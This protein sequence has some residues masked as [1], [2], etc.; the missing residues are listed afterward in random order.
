VVAHRLVHI[1]RVQTRGVEAGQPHVADDDDANAAVRV[2]ELGRERLHLALAPP[3]LRQLGRVV[4][5]GGD[6]ALDSIIAETLAEQP[7]HFGGDPARVGDDHRLAFERLDALGVVLGEI[8]GDL[9]EP[10]VLADDPFELRPGGDELVRPGGL[11]SLD[12]VGGRSERVG[13]G[14]HR[15]LAALVVDRDRRPILLRLPHPVDGDVVAEHEPRA[16]VRLLDR[17]P[18]ET[19]ARGVRECDR[20]VL[21][22]GRVLAPVRL[23]GDDDDVPALGEDRHPRLAGGRSELLNR[24]ED[25]PA[26]LAPGEQALQRLLALGDLLGSLRDVAQMRLTLEVLFELVVKVNAVGDADDGR[27]REARVPAE[28]RDEED[29]RVAL[30]GPLRVPDDASPAAIGHRPKELLDGGVHR[31]DLVVLRHHLVSAAAVGLEGDEVVDEVEERP[32]FEDAF[33]HRLQLRTVRAALLLVEALPLGEVLGRRR[34]RPEPRAQEVGDADDLHEAVQRRDRLGVVL[35]LVDRALGGRLLGAGV[36]QLDLPERDAVDEEEDVRPAVLRADHD[37]ELVDGEA[38]VVLW[39]V[40]V[41]EPQP[42]RAL[43]AALGPRRA[44]PAE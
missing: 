14:L 42:T 38:V 36:L 30:A 2:L 13:V 23:V 33:E 8:V 5:R 20:D 25:H 40:P 18:G 27:I 39:L 28:L 4:R 11:L 10:V 44:D 7:R 15:D 1:Q 43:L 3:V 16:A 37:P 34:D 12:H 19:N 17:R 21:G 9:C 31:V 41:D 6:D 29:H 24:R 35:N 26:G 32:R 22:E